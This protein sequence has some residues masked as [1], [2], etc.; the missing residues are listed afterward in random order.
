VATPLF[1]PQELNDAL[2]S[3]NDLDQVLKQPLG[4]AFI[5]LERVIDFR[6]ANAI[7]KDC[8][9]SARCSLAYLKLE[10]RDY[11]G[12]SNVAMSVLLENDEVYWQKAGGLRDRLHKQ[13]LACVRLYLSEALSVLGNPTSAMRLISQDDNS[14]FMNQLSVDL[15]GGILPNIDVNDVSKLLKAQIMVQT[16]ASSVSASMGDLSV[17]EQ[18]ALSALQTSEESLR[19]SASK[20]ASYK[21]SARKALLFCMLREGNREGALE[22]L[23]SA[24]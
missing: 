16:N 2:G 6:D 9:E 13:R 14:S 7:D 1:A 22:L 18:L 12:A 10:L 15:A 17:A 11:Q 3:P 5:C 24:W 8:L 4:R 23:A 19:G 21:M 20:T